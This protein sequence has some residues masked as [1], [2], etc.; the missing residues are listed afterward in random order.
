MS[1]NRKGGRGYNKSGGGGFRKPHLHR[2]LE[3]DGCDPKALSLL[4]DKKAGDQY[5]QLFNDQMEVNLA[6]NMGPSE[7]KSAAVT[8]VKESLEVEAARRKEM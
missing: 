3:H 5:L 7:A 2:C 4:G 8:F 6:R 1:K